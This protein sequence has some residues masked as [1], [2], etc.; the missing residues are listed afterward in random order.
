MTP[1]RKRNGEH[2]DASSCP[3]AQNGC[4][5]APRCPIGGR[6]WSCMWLFVHLNSSASHRTALRTILAAYVNRISPAEAHERVPLEQQRLQKHMGPCH[7]SSC[8]TSLHEQIHNLLGE[9]Y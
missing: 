9:G 1:V 4:E 2:G 8:S 7:S 6:D 5:F 3:G